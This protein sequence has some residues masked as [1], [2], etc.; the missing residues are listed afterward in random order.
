MHGTHSAI[1]QFSFGPIVNANGTLFRLWAPLAEIVTLKLCAS[2][3]LI[4][5]ERGED[6][7]FETHVEGLGVGELYLF[8]LPDGTEIP[9]PASRYQPL[10]VLGP[11]MICAPD[12]AWTD[13][14][15]RGRDWDEA[16][17]SEIHIGTFTPEGTF[18]AAIGKLDHL[19]ALGVTAIE[20]MPVHAFPGHQ[21]WGYDG[22]CLYAPHA[23]YGTPGDFKALVD[24]AHAR[25]LMVFLDVVYN[26]FGPEGN[27]MPRLMP[28][29]S[30]R[31]EGE[32]GTPPNLDDEDSGPVRQF[33]IE[34]ALY[35]LETFHCDGLRLDAVHEIVDESEPHLLSELQEA[36]R[37]RFEGRRSIHLIL[38]NSLNQACWLD[39]P[40][41]Y[42]AQWDD[43][44]HHAL[45]VAVTGEMSG[46][47]RDYTEPFDMLARAL[48][49]GF[50]FQ[51]EM[52]ADGTVKGE[53]SAHLAPTAFVTYVQN[54]DQIGNRPDGA[55]ITGVLGPAQVKAMTTLVILS[56]TIPMLF[57]G[58][59]W[60]ARTPFHY[61]SDLGEDLHQ[62]VR[63]SRNQFLAT[64]Q[65]GDV[66]A[67]DP[68][69][70]STFE[71]S[72]LDWSE[73]EHGEHAGWLDFYRRLIGTRTREIV[74]LLGGIGGHAGQAERIG[75]YA[76]MAQWRLGKGGRLDLLANLG[77][78]PW[79]GSSPVSG[80][81]IWAT[82]DAQAD[83]LGP[84]SVVAFVT[85]QS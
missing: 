60:A 83:G 55:R 63:Q 82:G 84:W 47:Y 66:E 35:W 22:V 51:G 56:P 32:Y 33:L 79:Q 26:H 72:R 19:V 40:N 70:A 50:A 46:F 12:F 77:P 52:L 49:E 42:R 28:L 64:W 18:G 2:G 8:V 6:G 53:P 71:M 30:R 48:Q 75:P 68:F 17:I 67:P 1:P 15:W 74:P 9:D 3:R 45:H 25:G 85:E 20:I 10:G 37:A 38:E 23:A 57:M 61:F 24:A 44:I 43:D 58:E 36:V 59:E 62:P 14:E 27:L 29:L 69:A 73:P 54:H 31:H 11:S 5:M 81:R 4:E 34:N 78:E 80:R 39:G 13:I 41:A 76:I 16:I 65:M 21:G 7:W